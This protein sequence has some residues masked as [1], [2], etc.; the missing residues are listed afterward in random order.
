MEAL[1]WQFEGIASCTH[2]T[3]EQL[4][5]PF[6]TAKC[7]QSTFHD[8][9]MKNMVELCRSPA[10]TRFCPLIC[11]IRKTQHV[12]QVLPDPLSQL[13]GQ[14]TQDRMR[15]PVNI[16]E[17]LWLGSHCIGHGQLG[18]TMVN[19]LNP[20]WL[21]KVDVQAYTTRAIVLISL[22]ITKQS[23]YIPSTYLLVLVC[24]C[25]YSVCTEYYYALIYTCIKWNITVAR[26]SMDRRLSMATRE[27]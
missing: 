20:A 4:R 18:S 16:L 17:P 10:R 1:L 6:D 21:Q 25:L 15:S 13:G 26:H 19:K 7:S 5:L 3:P 9:L 27:G 22:F 2:H 11:F 24:T 12:L 23:E 8:M 14:P